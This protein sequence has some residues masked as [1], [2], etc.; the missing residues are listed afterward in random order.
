MS[1]RDKVVWITGASS[2][3]G[4][5][6]ALAFAQQGAKLVLS[7]RREPELQRVKQ[8][9]GLSD[10][11]CLVLPMDM[12]NLNHFSSHVQAVLNHFGRVDIMVQNAG[13]SQRSLVKDTVFQ[14]YRDVM[15]L[16][17]FAV[18]AL[19][20][21]ILPHMIL[22]GRG[23]FVAISSV[24]GK[25]GV[26]YRGAYSAA[27]HALI[28]FFDALRAEHTNQGI[29]VTVVCPGYIRTAISYNSYDAAGGRHNKLDDNQAKGMPAD[30]CGRKIVAGV[31]A[32]RKEMYVGKFYEGFGMALKR[33]FPSLV[34]RMVQSVNIKE[35]KK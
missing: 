25:I 21:A 31:A 29:N 6:I 18:V 34:Y 4:E 16:D 5:G 11:D 15:E 7:A 20:Q 30:V 22:Q 26:P 27:K 14:V 28:G 3:I 32:N 35:A 10:T 2:G 23:H 17:Y 12:L 1:F 19:T 24:A 8:A 33:F 9:T 13:I